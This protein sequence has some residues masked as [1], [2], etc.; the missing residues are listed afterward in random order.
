MRFLVMTGF[1]G[2]IFSACASFTPPAAAA[3]VS[4][5]QAYQQCTRE[6]RGVG[7]GRGWRERRFRLLEHC[8]T[9]KR[10]TYRRP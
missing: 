5:Q 9:Q 7:H 1:A 2:L 4:L 6:I 8:V 3:T 10:G